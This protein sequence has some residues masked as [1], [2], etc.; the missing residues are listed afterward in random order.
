[1][2]RFY[3]LGDGNPV[4]FDI[5]LLSVLWD[6]QEQHGEA[7]VTNGGVLLG[8]SLLRGYHLFIDVIDGGEVRIEA[9]P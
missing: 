7:L 4:E 6:G 5:H 2:T 9:R 1:M 3:E 8:M